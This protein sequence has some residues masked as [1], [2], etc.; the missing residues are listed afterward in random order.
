MSTIFKNTFTRVVTIAAVA[1]L[2]ITAVG[3]TSAQAR[4]WGNGGHNGWHGNVGHH[5]AGPTHWDHARGYGGRYYAPRYYSAPPV[6]AY[7]PAYYGPPSLNFNI[8]LG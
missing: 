2:A 6:V 3:A 7:P 8:P 1:G 4:P 5:W